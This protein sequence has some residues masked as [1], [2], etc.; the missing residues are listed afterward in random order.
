MFPG[1]YSRQNSVGVALSEFVWEVCLKYLIFIILLSVYNKGRVRPYCY[2]FKVFFLL[3]LLWVRGVFH[4]C[5]VLQICFLFNLA[6][7]KIVLWYSILAVDCDS[8]SDR[9]IMGYAVALDL[10]LL[11]SKNLLIRI[12]QFQHASKINLLRFTWFYRCVWFLVAIFLVSAVRLELFVNQAWG[13]SFGFGWIV[14]A[15]VLQHF[16]NI[17]RKDSK[18]KWWCW[19][20]VDLRV[21]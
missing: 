12:F 19:L 21:S 17:I 6:F 13:H 3:N 10:H 15:H 9:I 11:I 20:W 8:A 5:C 4:S 18:W 1:P 2:F 7:K 14:S 16:I